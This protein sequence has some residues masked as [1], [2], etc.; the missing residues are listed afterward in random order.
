MINS[1]INRKKYNVY[2][3]VGDLRWGK[4]SWLTNYKKFNLR[5]C[6]DGFNFFEIN[7]SYYH[8]INTPQEWRE[9]ESKF[10]NL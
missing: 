4:P 5:L 9:A 10:K 8:D 3:N 7:K 2:F 1:K 6:R